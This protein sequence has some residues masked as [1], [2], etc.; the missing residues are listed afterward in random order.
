[1]ASIAYKLFYLRTR[2][3]KLS[4]AAM[5]EALGLRQ[6]SISFFEQGVSLPGAET[7]LELARFF[8]V[9]PTYLLDET[10]GLVV[11]PIDRWSLRNAH[12]TT[13]MWVEA[14]KNAL[15]TLADG[16]VLCPL[17]AGESFY[18]GEAM[19]ARCRSVE[20]GK[21]PRPGTK[22]ATPSRDAEIEREIADELLAQRKKR[23]TRARS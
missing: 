13:G 9:T 4:Q 17:L 20:A 15:V 6:A 18:D 5:A 8:D 7:L 16:K 1:M 10:R 14:P 11:Q 3:R 19:E 2:V 22:R 23:R 12:L 21:S